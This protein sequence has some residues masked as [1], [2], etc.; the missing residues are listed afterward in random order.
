[1][2]PMA[3]SSENIGRGER[4]EGEMD[5]GKGKERRKDRGREKEKVNIYIHQLIGR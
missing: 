4:R 3:G 1:M 2:S 5:G